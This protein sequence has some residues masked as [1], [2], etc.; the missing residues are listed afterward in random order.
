MHSK[1]HPSQLLRAKGKHLESTRRETMH[2]LRGE[3]YQDSSFPTG[4]HA[5]GR[6]AQLSGARSKELLCPECIRSEITL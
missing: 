6:R 3:N 5:A 2:H 1:T 4:S